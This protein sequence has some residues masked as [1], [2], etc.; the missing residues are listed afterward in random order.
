M[1][2]ETTGRAIDIRP[3]IAGGIWGEISSS[4][5]RSRASL[6]VLISFD[7]ST[8]LFESKNQATPLNRGLNRGWFK[9]K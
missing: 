8:L 9:E 7:F 5:V 6:E 3:V 4:E 2:P 1:P